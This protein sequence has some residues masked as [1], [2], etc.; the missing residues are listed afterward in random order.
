VIATRS[1]QNSA[2]DNALPGRR[3]LERALAFL[4]FISIVPWPTALA[5]NYADQSVPQARAAAVLYAATMLMMGLSFTSGWRYLAAHPELVAEPA[6]AAFPAGAR[7]ALLGGL[8]YL[9]A[10]AVA[11]LS[12]TASFAIDAIVAVYFAAS[13]SK[14]PGLIVRSADADGSS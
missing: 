14:V 7:R 5:S 1:C 11:F 12:P 13:K 10:I 9:A 8:V 3:F 6:R 2:G 4:L